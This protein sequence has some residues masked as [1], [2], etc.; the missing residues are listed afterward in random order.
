M[1]RDLTPLNVAI[2]NLAARSYQLNFATVTAAVNE[3]TIYY[4]NL[5]I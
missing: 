3:L 5:F 4:S 2:S 1:G